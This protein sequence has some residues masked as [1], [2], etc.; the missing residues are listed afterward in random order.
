MTEAIHFDI[1]LNR[2]ASAVNARLP[3]NDLEIERT[4]AA[5]KAMSHPLRLK[6]MCILGNREMSVQ[7]LTRRVFAT[8]QSNVSQHL[9]QMLERQVLV[10]RKVG[11]QVLYR[12]R[13]PRILNLI[14]VMRT[15]FCD[16]PT[17]H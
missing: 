1:E 15:I 13:D 12:I 8:T 6:L 7:E 10:N 11:N 9:S 17:E 3:K 14:Q 2:L 4:A 16:L 5:I